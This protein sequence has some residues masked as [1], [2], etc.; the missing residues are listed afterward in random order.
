MLGVEK[1]FSRSQE[2]NTSR[3]ISRILAV[4]TFNLFYKSPEIPVVV[5]DFRKLF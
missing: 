4:K 1:T 5:S 2:N 3:L